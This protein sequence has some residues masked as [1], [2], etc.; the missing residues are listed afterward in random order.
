MLVGRLG[1]VVRSCH[2]PNIVDFRSHSYGQSHDIV[3][4]S[5]SRAHA[6]RTYDGLVCPKSLL[7]G[8]L[9]ITLK[10]LRNHSSELF[11]TNISEKLTHWETR[12]RFARDVLPFVYHRCVTTFYGVSIIAEQ[13]HVRKSWMSRVKHPMLRLNQNVT[14]WSTCSYGHCSY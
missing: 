6:H 7:L 1:V 11:Q 8:C 3:R 14:T 12:G 4:L 13:E 5:C 9:R 10:A 2:L